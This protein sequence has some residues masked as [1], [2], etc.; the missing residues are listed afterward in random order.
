MIRILI[1]IRPLLQNLVSEETKRFMINGLSRVIAGSPE[2][3]WYILADTKDPGGISIP[4]PTDHWLIRKSYPW[5]WGW[6]YWY[7][8]QIPRVIKKQSMDLL[9]TTGGTISSSRIPQC[10]WM[11]AVKG[12][13]GVKKAGGYLTF[14]KK[15]LRNTLNKARALFVFSKSDRKEWLDPAG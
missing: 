7:D 10:V 9:I 15:R 12:E 8:W 13:N 1:E 11:P 3:S 2:N 4:I 6:K 5:P 14:Y